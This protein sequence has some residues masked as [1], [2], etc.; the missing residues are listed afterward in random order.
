MRSAV[1]LIYKDQKMPKNDFL[2]RMK[3]VFNNHRGVSAIV[4]GDFNINMKEDNSL[5]NTAYSEGFLPLVNCGTTIHDSLLDQIF[6]NATPLANSTVTVT[7]QSYFS[8]HD[9]VVLCIPK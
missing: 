1:S 8:D 2:A 6:V 9:L 4:L 3:T 5:A 7:L